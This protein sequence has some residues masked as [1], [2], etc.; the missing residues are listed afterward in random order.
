[1]SLAVSILAAFISFSLIGRQGLLPGFVIGA[2]ASGQLASSYGFLAP[3][4]A[5]DYN[6]SANQILTT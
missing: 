4:L 1:M 6:L 3:S 5:N 2:I